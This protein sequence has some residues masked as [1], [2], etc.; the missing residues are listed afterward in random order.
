MNIHKIIFPQAAAL[1]QQYGGQ[2]AAAAAALFQQ[3][4]NQVHDFFLS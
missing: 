4:P 3:L 2:Q 1:Q